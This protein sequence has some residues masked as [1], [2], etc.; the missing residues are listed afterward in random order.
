M[1][2]PEVIVVGGG[3]VGAACAW[4]L[5]GRGLDVLLLEQRPGFGG[6]ASSAAMGHLIVLDDS[7]AQFRLT[8]TSQLLWDELA[9]ELPPEVER[10]PCG[11]I[12]IAEDGVQME[13]ARAKATFY[14]Q[15]GVRVEVLDPQ[16]LAEAE[17]ELRPDLAGGLL[18]L[19]DTVV[20]PPAFVRWLLDRG[21]ES[22][23][24]V[25]AGI[26]VVRVRGDGVELADGS[27]QPAGRVVNAAGN[28]A[29]DLLPE[30]LSGPVIRP[31][32]GHLA[33]T[34]RV[35]GFCRHQLAEL[36]YHDSAHGTEAVSVAFNVQ[37]RTTGQVLVGSSRQ[38]DDTDRAVRP[39]VLSRMLTRA[40][41]FLPRLPELPV[42]RTWTGFRPSTDDNLPLVGEVPDREGLYLAAGHEGFGIT[43]CLGTAKLAAA[44]VTDSPP[45]IDPEPYL[46]GRTVREA[47]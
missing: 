15:R 33:I 10:D 35:P 3:I 44:W 13:E 40:A 31:R 23:L 25:R 8:R 9:E 24:L 21:R 39:P 22:G 19:E 34:D 1:R 7:E 18:M 11:C 14:E 12:W 27:F 20:Y 16:A 43:T 46:P 4:E 17:P 28:R 5:S 36:G 30:P 26:E 29:L 32:K 2:T 6:G 37:P 47:A 45:P 38:F 41:E 42:I